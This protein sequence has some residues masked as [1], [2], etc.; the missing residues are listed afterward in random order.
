MNVKQECE[1]GSLMIYIKKV[2]CKHYID[3]EVI[4][5]ASC[6]YQQMRP[7]RSS[8]QLMVML[9]TELNSTFSS[10]RQPEITPSRRAQTVFYDLIY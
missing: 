8:Q 9:S 5:N 1:N 6:N 2:R 3:G 7:E 10:S 4:I